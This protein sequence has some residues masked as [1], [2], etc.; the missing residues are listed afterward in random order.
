MDGTVE[1]NGKPLSLT[2][3]GD[4]PE[5]KGESVAKGSV[6]LPPA[7]IAFFAIPN[8]GNASCR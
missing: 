1:L 8:A 4:L 6:E 3:A 5:I 2:A 7:S